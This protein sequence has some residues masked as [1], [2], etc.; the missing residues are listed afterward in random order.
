MGIFKVTN[1][2]KNVQ[3]G[4]SPAALGLSPAQGWLLVGELSS[5]GLQESQRE[6]SALPSAL[7]GSRGSQRPWAVTLRN[8]RSLH[9]GH[10]ALGLGPGHTLV[11]LERCWTC[12]AVPPEPWV[13]A[14][15]DG[16]LGPAEQSP[17]FLGPHTPAT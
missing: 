7:C 13:G 12:C 3:E 10:P 1:Q 9:G 5:L 16:S 6:G 8:L 11:G 14:G 15:M 4:V 17:W 2:H